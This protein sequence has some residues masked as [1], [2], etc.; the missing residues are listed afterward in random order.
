MVVMGAATV[1][2][3]KTKR[4][5][6]VDRLEVVIRMV[7]VMIA[8]LLILVAVREVLLQN[9]AQPLVYTPSANPAASHG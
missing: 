2:V 3:R 6:V 1:A 9:V 7:L 8:V 4:P 5:A